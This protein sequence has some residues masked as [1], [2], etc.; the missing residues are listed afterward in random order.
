MGNTS[1]FNVF[2]LIYLV[3]EFHLVILA[4]LFHSKIAQES[5]KG[6]YCQIISKISSIFEAFLISIL[7]FSLS[8]NVKFILVFLSRL[9]N[10]FL[11][12]PSYNLH[13]LTFLINSALYTRI[14]HLIID[15]Y[16]TITHFLS[17][18]TKIDKLNHAKVR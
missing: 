7:F 4:K 1:L 5:I 14:N 15:Y 17:K 2:S 9:F 13:L 10:F 12:S 8:F 11:V 3:L 6:S 18:N 16:I